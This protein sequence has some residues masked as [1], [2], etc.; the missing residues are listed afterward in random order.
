MR[1]QDCLPLMSKMYLNRIVDSFI[2][3]DLPKGNEDRL[4]EQIQQNLE[5][6]ASEER[7]KA[8]LELHK[9][10]RSHRI[11]SESILTNLLELPEMSCD[12]DELF[13]KIR[14]YEKQTISRANA[15]DAFVYSDQK[16]LELYETVLQVALEDDDI[17]ES[18]FLLL[19]KLRR[20]LTLSRLE[21]RMLEVRLKAYPKAGNEL[22]S[23][24][25]FKEAIKELQAKG[26]VFFCN[27]ADNVNLLVLP[28][29]ISTTIKSIL[30]YELREEAFKLLLQELTVN[31]LRGVLA[32]FELPLAGTKDERIDRIIKAGV[33]PSEALGTLHTNDLTSLCR[34]LK[35]INVSGTKNEKVAR[36]IDY[37]G[38]LSNKVPTDS[39]DSREVYYQY[40]EELASRNNKELYIKKLIKKDIQIESYFEKA[41][42]FLFEDKLG[43]K[44]NSQDGSEHSDGSVSMKNGDLLL[45]DNKSKEKEYSF[46]RSHFKQFRRYIRESAKRVSVFL[47]IVSEIEKS[48]ELTAR[49]LKLESDTDTDVAIIRAR[50]LKYVAENWTEFASNAKNEFDLKV[51]NYTG[52]LERSTLEQNMKIVL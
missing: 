7:I 10:P 29:E 1:I 46:P 12:A 38:S 30:G 13:K 23:L 50:D 21:H 9:M 35:G 24:T 25:D 8:S 37:F 5:E 28:E 27:L 44:L 20:K 3:E 15:D 33:L 11:L 36:V 17:N 22:H 42:H 39:R 32:T 52:V 26:I 31:Q 14:D 6:L 18:E 51:F 48:A 47:I 41:T 49:Q 45:W 4:R 43:L 40:Y 19:E 34:K 16:S 2:K